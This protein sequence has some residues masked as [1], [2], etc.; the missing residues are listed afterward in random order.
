RSKRSGHPQSEVRYP[1]VV[2]DLDD[3]DKLRDRPGFNIP[4]RQ[5]LLNYFFPPK[6]EPDSAIPE[7]GIRNPLWD[8]RSAP[9]YE[10]TTID[11]FEQPLEVLERWDG[12]RYIAVL[13]KKLVICSDENPYGV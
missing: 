8:A 6:E 13:Q 11:P 9:R 4:D 12:K 1:P 7:S 2:R 10:E 5:T 3:L